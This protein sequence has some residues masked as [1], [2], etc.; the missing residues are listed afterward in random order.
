MYSTN[1][2]Q[3]SRDTMYLLTL[4]ENEP[5]M[6]RRIP[7]IEWLSPLADIGFAS[8]EPAIVVVKS[9]SNSCASLPCRIDRQHYDTSL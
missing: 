4:N 3:K 9:L 8:D 5:I 2:V 1:M 7:L 6:M